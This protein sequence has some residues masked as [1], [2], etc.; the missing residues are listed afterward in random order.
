MWVG[1]AKEKS[2]GRISWKDGVAITRK[3]RYEEDEHFDLNV[4]PGGR[5]SSPGRAA[6][7][8]GT[9]NQKSGM[10]RKPGGRLLSW[11]GLMSPL[12]FSS[13]FAAVK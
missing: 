9:E 4:L 13:D 1:K 3:G 11:R 12:N 2:L 6:R 5:E 10:C 8:P 7:P